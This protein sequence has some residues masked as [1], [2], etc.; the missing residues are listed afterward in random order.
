MVD[1]QRTRVYDDR[2]EGMVMSDKGRTGMLREIKSKSFDPSTL[3]RG[4][5]AGSSRMTQ[6][7]P[8]GEGKV[9]RK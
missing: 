1:Q 7:G 5:K 3:L 9:V 8:K 2:C 6:F 4:V